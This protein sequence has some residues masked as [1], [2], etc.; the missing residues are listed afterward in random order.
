M[1]NSYLFAILVLILT[2]V[3]AQTLDSIAQHYVGRYDVSMRNMLPLRDG[4]VLVNCQLYEL[5]SSQ[6]YIVG[7]S[8]NRFLKINPDIPAVQDSAFVEDHDLNYFLMERNPFGD[9]NIYA[10]A[11]RDLDNLRTDLCI[12]F[13]DDQFNFNDDKEVWVPLLSDTVFVA[14][15]DAY[16]LDKYGDIIIQLAVRSRQEHHFFRIGIDGV[17]KTHR[18]YSYDEFPVEVTTTTE[19]LVLFNEEPLE[20]AYFGEKPNQELHIVVFD[21]LLNIKDNFVPAS[22]DP[23][24]EL[25]YGFADLVLDLDEASFLMSSQ[26]RKGINYPIKRGVHVTRYDK[27]T[28]QPLKMVVF[29]AEPGNL[30]LQ[31]IPIGIGVA[32]NGDV[33]YAY[34]TN[35]DY[36][37]GRVVVVRMDHDLNIIWRRYCLDEGF[38]R[39]GSQLKILDDGSVAVGGV[40]WGWGVA[41]GL[42]SLYFLF[43]DNNG[44]GIGEHADLLRPY[45][46]Y[47]NPVNE[48]LNIQYSPDVKLDCVEIFDLQGRKVISQRSNME[49]IRTAELPSGVYTIRVTLE[50]GQTYTDKIVKQ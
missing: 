19:D 23:W 38:I 17:I 10:R 43:L 5:D 27:A 29:S 6:A 41:N 15:T 37:T 40:V 1:K 36:A 28:C 22:G 39:T 16:L 20:Y 35:F 3:H 44:V 45:T 9:D 49:S 11:V 2:R 14:S 33:Y 25:R 4:T 50:G 32:P 48:V 47:P 7:D 30:D 34:H 8:G 42:P 24:L 26:W 13:F 12:R 18:V 21:S 31:A 46:F